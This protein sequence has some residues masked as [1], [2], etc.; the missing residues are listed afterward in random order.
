MSFQIAGKVG[1]IL[2]SKDER[3]AVKDLSEKLEIAHLYEREVKDLSGGE[4]QR[5]ACAVAAATASQV[6]M[7][8]EP[9]SY[10]DVKQRLAASRMIRKLIED[11]KDNYVIVVEH[12]LAVLDYLSD[13]VCCLWGA[14]GAYGVVSMPASVREGINMF[15]EGFLPSE[16][17][18]FRDHALSFKTAVED[19][20]IER[21]HAC[22][23]P[24][25]CKRLGTFELD[26]QP[27]QYSDSEIQ[28]MLGQ[29]GEYLLIL[30]I[31]E[32]HS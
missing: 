2:K 28:V 5:F 30:V 22:P 8:D 11:S 13:Y 12:D 21:L 27:G 17:L 1:E 4:L 16:N 9:S 3:G 20:N 25:M 32:L 6:Y 26:I 7:F 14:A 10:L 18:R 23:W 29:N 31:D 19:L 15:L 24:Q